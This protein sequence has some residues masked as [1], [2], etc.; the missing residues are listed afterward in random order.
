M[1]KPV[2]QKKVHSNLHLF[3]VKCVSP[4]DKQNGG[5]PRKKTI[6]TFHKHKYVKV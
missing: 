4:A 1:M 2:R 6:G 5:N 3:K